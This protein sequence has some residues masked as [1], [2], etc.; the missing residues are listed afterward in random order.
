MKALVI[1]D[2]Q[3]D[4]TSGGN[5][6]V[7][8]GENIIPLINKIQKKFDLVVATQDWHPTNH[9]SFSSNHEGKSNFDKIILDGLEQVLWP[10]HCIQGSHGA[11]F[12]PLLDTHRVETIF[13]KGM[14]ANIDSYS[15]FYDNGHRKSTGLSG[16]LRERK[17]KEVFL[18]GLAGDFCV[19]YTSMDALKEGF[20]T[21]YI[22]DA[23]RSINMK[24]FENAKMEIRKAGGSVISSA[25]LLSSE[26]L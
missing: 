16:Y 22:D 2:V 19:F 21:F 5:L 4:F 3:N 15:G 1:V 7:P 18:C 12:H 23:T 24:G 6:A 11:E 14:D 26:T 10:D 9:K 13:R 25:V 8:D 17:V 20:R